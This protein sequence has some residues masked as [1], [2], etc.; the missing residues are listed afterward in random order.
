M[1]STRR[2]GQTIGR[3]T[4]DD[5]DSNWLHIFHADPYCGCGSDLTRGSSNRSKSRRIINSVCIDAIRAEALMIARKEVRAASRKAQDA[6]QI[7][8]HRRRRKANIKHR[9]ARRTGNRVRVR[10]DKRSVSRNDRIRQVDMNASETTRMYSGCVR[11]LLSDCQYLEWFIGVG[12]EPDPKTHEIVEVSPL[13][14][15]RRSCCRRRR[16]RRRRCRRRRR[17]RRR[18]V[19]VASR[20]RRSNWT[21]EKR[22]TRHQRRRMTSRE[23]NVGKQTGQLCASNRCTRSLLFLR[24]NRSWS[25]TVR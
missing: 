19:V 9:R 8:W 13:C 24:Y 3:F 12:R 18:C 5:D 21:E 6:A 16:R 10:E 11:R 14:S 23:T 20:A 25:L 1:I 2:K 4:E 22:G 7:E 15:R 17:R